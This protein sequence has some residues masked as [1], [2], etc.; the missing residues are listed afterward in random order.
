MAILKGAGGIESPITESFIR[1]IPTLAILRC[2]PLAHGHRFIPIDGDRYTDGS[3]W[4]F[5]SQ[6]AKQFCTNFAGQKPCANVAPSGCC[7]GPLDGFLYLLIMTFTSAK[8]PEDNKISITYE[9]EGNGYVVGP[10]AALE[11]LMAFLQARTVKISNA[12][13]VSTSNDLYCF[14]FVSVQTQFNEALSDWPEVEK[15]TLHYVHP[16][17]P[18]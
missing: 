3:E 11:E 10:R 18:S 16:R 8:S 7:V 9:T 4:D 12:R 2:L 13:P 15:Y 5:A 14:D 1:P 17:Q 6:R